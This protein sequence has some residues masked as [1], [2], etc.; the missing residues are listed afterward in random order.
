MAKNPATN[1]NAEMQVAV[2]SET[3]R[4]AENQDWMSWSRIP[5]GECYIVADGMG[6]YK[7]GA[8]AARMTVEGL[9]SYLKAQP[10]DRPFEQALQEAVSRTNAEVYRA[11]QSGNPETDHMGSTLAVALISGNQLLVGHIGDS[12]IYLV[13]RG[14]LKLLTTDHT[15]VQRMVDAGMIT[16][17]QARGHP[18]A[19]ILSRAIGSKPDV[20]IEIGKP[21]PLESGDGVLLCSDGLSGYVKDQQIEKLVSGTSDVQRIPKQLVDLALESGGDDNV[22]VQFVRYGRPERRGRRRTAIYGASQSKRGRRASRIATGAVLL[23]GILLALPPIRMRLTNLLHPSEG[24]ATGTSNVTGTSGGAGTTSGTIAGAQ[25]S[26]PG[27]V[28][29]NSP[30]ATRV[31]STTAR[32]NAG[33]GK[34]GVTGAAV[35][36][37]ARISTGA[38]AAS[39]TGTATASR[40]GTTTGSRTGAETG[41]TTS[42]GATTGPGTRSRASAGSPTGAG[43]AAGAGT[44]TGTAAAASAP[45]AIPVFLLFD[46]QQEQQ[47]ADDI[48]QSLQLDPPLASKAQTLPALGNQNAGALPE[49]C[50]IYYADESLALQAQTLQ[51]ALGDLKVDDCGDWKRGVYGGRT[52]LKDLVPGTARDRHLLIVLKKK[53]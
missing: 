43:S 17:E 35:G 5:W 30:S 31:G 8:L 14:K 51:K 24:G 26:R 4:R 10:A 45:E 13:R 2:L 3:G 49:H 27:P 33:R 25:P 42:A 16:E 32:S 22:T 41:A 38:G 44:S 28:A 18:E 23:A 11:A 12:R 47:I 34:P 46:A 7:G 39:G 20:E 36:V 6:G 15:S 1:G 29:G 40:T 37:G 50:Y 9:E 53:D 52:N 19:H 21:I 48:I